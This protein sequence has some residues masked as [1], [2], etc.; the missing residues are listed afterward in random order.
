MALAGGSA[1]ALVFSLNRLAAEAYRRLQP[2]VERQ[3]SSSLGQPVELGV[4]RGL[5][6]QGLRLGA[7]RVRSLPSH[8]SGVE[9]A[10]IGL[11]LDPIASLRRRLPV[12]EVNLEGVEANL[13]PN[14]QGSYWRLPA[15]D[16]SAEPP[17]LV[18]RVRLPQPA[19]VRIE[20]AG[21]HSQLT[22]RGSVVIEPQRN[23]ASGLLQLRPG[24]SA[25]SN[26][27][28]LQLRGGGNWRANRWQGRLSSRG[29]ALKWPAAL[30][31]AGGVVDGRVD[32]QLQLAWEA[33]KPRCQG[34]LRMGPVSWRAQASQPALLLD[35]PRLRCQGTTVTLAQSGWS[36]GERS[37]QF[38]LQARWQPDKLLLEQLE[39]SS[40]RS[41]LWARG[42][43]TPDPVLSGDWQLA[44]ADLPLPPGVGPELVGSQLRGSLRLAGSWSRPQLSTRVSQASNPLLGPWQASLR[45]R[46][47]R[48]LLDQLASAHL[49][50]RGS[51]PLSLVA[52]QGLRSGALDL[53]LRLDRYPLPRLSP[54]LGADLRGVVDAEGTIRGPLSGLTPEFFL[55]LDQPGAGPLLVAETWSGNWFGDPAGG[56]RLR[57]AS[58]GQEPQGRLEA[59]LDRRWVPVAVSL[60]RGSGQLALQGSPRAYDWTARNFPLEGVQLALGP[61]AQLRPLRGGLSGDGVLELQPLAFRGRVELDQPAV[62]GVAAKRVALEGSYRDRRYRAEGQILAQGGGELDLDWSGRWQ[63]EYVAHLQGRDLDDG[64]VRRLLE[65]WPRWRGEPGPDPGSAADLGTLLIDTLGGSIDDQLAALNQA[66]ARLRQALVDQRERLTPAERLE[67]VAARFDLEAELSGPRLA[68]TRIDASVQGHLWFPG[69]DRDQA[70]TLE[71]L[72]LEFTG[73]VRMGSGS[74]AFSGVPLALLA[75]FTPVPEEL[76][77]TLSSKGRYRLASGQDPELALELTLEDA[78]LGETELALERGSVQL[79]GNSLQ[80]D[81][82]LRAAGAGSGIDLAGRLPLDPAEEGIELRLTSRDDGLI[83]LSRLAQP[84]LVWEEGSADLQLLVRGS[85]NSPIANGFLRLQDGRLALLGQEVEE[86]QATLLFDFE[87]LLLE[88][89]T[90][91]VGAEGRVSGSG[92]LGLFSPHRDAEGE[93]AQLAIAVAD[94][95]FRQPRLQATIDGD[96]QV[97]GSLTNLE[98]GG[99]LALAKGLVNVQP[100]R[101]A[102]EEGGVQTV[103]SVPELAEQRWDFQQPLVLLGPEL[104]E[105][106]G[107]DFRALVP[108]VRFLDFRGL[109][110]SL[111]PDFSVVIPQLAD[112]KTSGNLRID[113]PLSPD[114]EARGVVK[115]ERGRLNL[116]TTNFYL[117][118]N[119]PN[120]A[121]FAPSLGLVPFLDIT[122]RTRVSDTIAPGVV[123]GSAGSSI[124]ATA[125]SQEERRSGV[126]SL[127]QLN[128]V[129]V[130]LS[131]SGPANRVADGISLRS[132]PPLPEDRLLALIGGNSL[133]GLGGSAAGTALA[134]V[135]GQ[136]LLSPLL[137][138]LGEA[139]GERLSF[140]LYPAFVSQRVDNDSNRRSGRVPPQLVLATEVGV[141]VSPQFNFS[142]IAAP[143]RSDVPPQVNLTFRASELLNLQG[144][145]DAQGAWQ[146]QLQ[147]FFRF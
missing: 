104:Q 77:G 136:T 64:L 79:A 21:V 22:L 5:G 20:R 11:R 138:T 140:A 70:L 57:L 103:A 109:R 74:F 9:L 144:S 10:G 129:Q 141:D 97:G 96:L 16:P 121:V 3:L 72:Q 18:A 49:S 60:S 55:R 33:G 107:E 113:G 23:Q 105:R 24:D 81:V 87:Q 122:L 147:V 30:V 90:A 130:F 14:A 54:L 39:L 47:Q 102:G 124:N 67:K 110:V 139:F 101:L 128:L 59:R 127:D 118:R 25:L 108:N 78:T 76:R 42:A 61:G 13:R 145:L 86:L 45:W 131:V 120:V 6:W 19:L 62:L 41:W 93:P 83:F 137:G 50:G 26:A 119:S 68:D 126:S 99:S 58:R 142:V 43:L 98:V 95:P 133:A 84:A 69:Q 112:F 2:G 15:A 28:S 17:G 92:S 46:D 36:W 106:E 56:G 44:P 66:H 94:M 134:T 65:A 143:N 85:L 71:P 12:L 115:L 82:A 73:P 116:F 114:L 111:G 80:V 7:S 135:V 32:G 63:G 48:L 52:G 8:P 100:G 91:R 4:F 34:E 75:L 27:G 53:S 132:T 146:T 31:A 88:E 29:V 1:T 125:I 38:G 37:G 117:D 123:S 51:L 40:G 89:F 35:R